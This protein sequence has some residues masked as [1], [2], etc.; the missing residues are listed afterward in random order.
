MNPKNQVVTLVADPFPPYQYMKG[1]QVAGLDHDIIRKAFE[2]QDFNI[3]VTLHPWAECIQRM[4]QEATDGIFQMARTSEREKLYLF[5]NLLRIARTVFYC[6][7]RKP[8]AVDD[9]HRLTEQLRD[10]RIAV[11]KGYSYG[12]EF[13]SLQ[14]LH[15][16]PVNSH[17]E[18]LLELSAKN[19][20]L[21][22]ID[23]GVAVHLM[24][25]LKLAGTLQ[26]VANFEIERPLFVAF[27]KTMPRIRET[28]N[29]GL[30][31]IRKNGTYDGLMS[32]YKLND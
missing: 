20:D 2:S 17:R 8:V 9:G 5:S 30:E 19:V 23:E 25:E 6:N 21:A 26:K 31:Q 12:P 14:D 24:D 4:D 15:G 7:K 18:S 27:Q 13:D 22:I 29:R 16:T 32:R 3:S 1:S 10:N 28:F 11:V